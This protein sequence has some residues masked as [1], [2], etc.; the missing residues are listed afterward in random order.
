MARPP[1]S[2]WPGIVGDQLDAPAKSAVPE[3]RGYCYWCYWPT[4]YSSR[5]RPLSWLRSNNAWTSPKNWASFVTGMLA[6]TRRACVEM[7]RGELDNAADRIES[8]AAARS[9]D[10]TNGEA[11]LV[12]MAQ[13]IELVRARAEPAELTSFVAA[14]KS[15]WAGAPILAN[16]LGAGFLARAGDL[17]GARRHVATVIDL[18]GWRAD[19]SYAWTWPG[20][21]AQRGGHRTQ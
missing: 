19:R 4:P 17:A 1:G 16:S 11:A 15:A 20:P 13:R 6:E 14:A 7:Q 2:R 9:T 10:P 3:P 5:A 21:G 8:A 12:R 18:G